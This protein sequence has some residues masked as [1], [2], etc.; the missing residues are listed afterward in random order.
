MSGLDTIP[1]EDLVWDYYYRLYYDDEVDD[2]LN[3]IYTSPR[4]MEEETTDTTPLLKRKGDDGNDDAGNDNKV[5]DWDTDISQVPA[6][7]DYQPSGDSDRTNPFPPGADST[8]AGEQIPL[9]TITSVSKEHQQGSRTADTSLNERSQSLQAIAEG[10]KESVWAEI[11]WD[12]PSPD[13]S[14]LDVRRVEAPR[15]GQ[16]RG[17]YVI[18]LSLKGR[19]KWYRFYTKSPGDT[20]ATFNEHLPQ[21]INNALGK[22]TD[23]LFSE[24]NTALEINQQELAEKQTQLEQ[25]E[26]RAAER[27]KLRHDLDA[28]RNRIKETDDRIEEL[29]NKYGSLNTEAIVV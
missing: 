11:E 19:N 14:A 3:S 27:Q 26:Q 12:F 4:T 20:K 18:E 25:A 17:G 6:P 23:E 16:G 8:P 2:F 21:A 9:D 22:T 1:E 7:N 13:K 5:M 29:E 28:I 24:T 10:Q 15:L